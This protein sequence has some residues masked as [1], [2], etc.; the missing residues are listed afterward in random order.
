MSVAT[1]VASFCF[2]DF[3]FVGTLVLRV[4]LRPVFGFVALLGLVEVDVGVAFGLGEV[5]RS[6]LK[7]GSPSSSNRWAV[8]MSQAGYLG[9]ELTLAANCE[10]FRRRA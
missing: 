2:L 9:E 10:L 8:S 1:A 7:M 6:K 5:G 3:F 4:C